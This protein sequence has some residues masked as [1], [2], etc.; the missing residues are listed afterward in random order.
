MPEQS[1]FDL[2]N[3]YYNL[4]SIYLLFTICRLQYKEEETKR[5]N[6]EWDQISQKESSVSKL[7]KPA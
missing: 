1:C 2:Y 5:L 7:G 4:Q 6:V 3:W